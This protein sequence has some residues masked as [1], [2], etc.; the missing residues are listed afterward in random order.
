MIR[1]DCMCSHVLCLTR[2]E[3]IEAQFRWVMLTWVLCRKQMQHN[4]SLLQGTCQDLWSAFVWLHLMVQ[5]IHVRAWAQS[6]S[7][8]FM[9]IQSKTLKVQCGKRGTLFWETRLQYMNCPIHI[10]DFRHC[11]QPKTCQFKSFIHACTHSTWRG[12]CSTKVMLS[13]NIVLYKHYLL[14]PPRQAS[15]VHPV[16]WHV[17]PFRAALSVNILLYLEGN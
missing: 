4:G 9:A 6:Y 13:L 12:L 16:L 2:C 10:R 1:L 15:S 17:R 3:V 14:L 11:G 8:S 7:K 5:H